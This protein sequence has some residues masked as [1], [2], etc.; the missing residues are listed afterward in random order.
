MITEKHK[1]NIIN[2]IQFFAT[3]LLIIMVMIIAGLGAFLW[4]QDIT[5]IHKDKKLN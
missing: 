4:P 2:N 1:I 5:S 3:A